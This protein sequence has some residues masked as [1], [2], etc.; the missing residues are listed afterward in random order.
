MKTET[1]ILVNFENRLKE[2]KVI[3]VPSK[4]S[5]CPYYGWIW[6]GGWR[7]WTRILELWYNL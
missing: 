3:V 1:T 2:W 4:W 7:P 5:W 6:I